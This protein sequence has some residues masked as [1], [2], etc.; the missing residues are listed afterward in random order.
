MYLRF[1][2]RI[3]G[4]VLLMI[5][6]ITSLVFVYWFYRPNESHQISE[7]SIETWNVV[8]NGRH[9]AFSDLIYWKGAFYLAYRVS[10][11]HS[12]SSKSKIVI[13]S[14]PDTKKW[15]E[16]TQLDGNG[17]DIRD[18]KFAIV[19]DRL[20]I[21]ALKNARFLAFPTSSAYS[22]SLDGNS[23]TKF[24][25]LNFPGWLIWRP[26]TTDS[27]TWYA[28]FYWYTLGESYLLKSTDCIKWNVA[29]KLYKGDNTNETEMTFLN[30]STLM[31]VGRAVSSN[32]SNDSPEGFTVIFKSAFP[33]NNWLSYKRSF[34][35]R[36]DGPNLFTYKGNVYAIGRYQPYPGGITRVFDDL[37][38]RKRTSIFLVKNYELIYLTDILSDGDTSY[39]GEV[40]KNDTLYFSYYTSNITKDYPWILGMFNPTSVRIG[41]LN[42]NILEKYAYLKSLH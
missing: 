35:T 36:L 17:S 19:K 42:L 20:F 18:P 9:N 2:T 33:F 13:M 40:I 14:S 16:L 5:I 28:P 25:D 27:V 6:V 7:L 32:N 24:A 38:S 15:K 8:D 39:S 3:T 11:F 23:W 31:A 29:G 1:F 22:Y 4:I 21:F 26:R 12:G 41:R 30:D 34:V 37:F 10:D